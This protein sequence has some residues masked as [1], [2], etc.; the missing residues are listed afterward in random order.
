MYLQCQIAFGRHISTCICMY[1]K[2]ASSCFDTYLGFGTF[3]LV[4]K[5]ISYYP[6]K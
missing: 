1:L 4:A 3:G 5:S 2:P 6:S